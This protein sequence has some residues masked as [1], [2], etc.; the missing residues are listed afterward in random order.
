MNNQDF[1]ITSLQPWD[2]EIGSTIKNTAMEISKKNRV[3]YI[4]TP[5]DYSTWI[6]GKKNTS[7]QQNIDVI[8]KRRT[9]IRK[10]KEN[11]WII[12]CPFFIYSINM[13]PTKW[14]FDFFNKKNNRRIGK[15][16]LKVIKELGFKNF[17][18]IIDTDIYRSQYLKEIIKPNI[19]IYYCR[20]FVIGVD[21][22]KK[23]G[24]RLEPILATKS[25]IVLTNSSYFAER[26]KKY[27]SNTYPLETGVNLELY[28][29]SKK[30]DIPNDIQAIPSPIVGYVGSLTS[31]RLDIELL[32]QLAKKKDK[33]NFVFVG[34]EDAVFSQHPL[35]K[36][37]NVH[38]L[39]AKNLKELPGYINKFDVCINPQIVNDIT[40]GNYPLKIDEYLAMG[41]PVVAT[42]THTMRDIFDKYTFLASNANGYSIEIDKAI[43]E[44]GDAQKRKE[45]IAFAHTHSWE[46]SV[47]KIYNSIEQFK[48]NNNIQ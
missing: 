48:R 35:H 18:H 8:K 4:N 11:L 45:R 47:N 37:E 15:H 28:D 30:W 1:I 26:F 40:I 19:S 44:I 46:N 42:D 43:S 33:Y 32:Y 17:I 25:D 27:N 6:K 22:W 3:I 36:L 12:D 5:M 10:I 38:F 7:Y 31:L 9:Y 24:K 13:L 2:I 29:A 21:Y 20:D 34:P 14:L 23:N 16:I 39:G 41:K